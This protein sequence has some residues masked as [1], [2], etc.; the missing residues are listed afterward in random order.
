MTV[1][2][3][4]NLEHRHLFWVKENKTNYHEKEQGIYKKKGIDAKDKLL[5][6]DDSGKEADEE[7]FSVIN[8]STAACNTS[9]ESDREVSDF[10]SSDDYIFSIL[11]L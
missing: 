1:L 3:R 10:L 8:S 7:L 6:S 2:L 5:Q 9:S 11:I 4:R